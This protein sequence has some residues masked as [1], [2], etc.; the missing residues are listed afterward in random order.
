MKKIYLL[1]VWAMMSMGAFAD[2]LPLTGLDRYA[3]WSYPLIA[4]FNAQWATI[5]LVSAD[6]S[7]SE[8]YRYRIV[9]SQPAP[10][11]FQ[12]S[13]Q[14]AAEASAYSGQYLPIDSGATVVAGEFNLSAFQDGDTYVTDFRLQSIDSKTR[15]AYI[16]SVILYNEY[17]EPSLQVP[18][19]A[20]WSSGTAIS[21]NGPFVFN[22]PSTYWGTTYYSQLGTWNNTLEEGYV[23]RITLVTK[24]TIPDG[25]VFRYTY[26]QALTQEKDTTLVVETPVPRSTSNTFSFDIP[27]TYNDLALRFVG[28]Q[29]Q[30]LAVDRIDR[31]TLFIPPLVYDVENT[32]ATDAEPDYPSVEEAPLIEKLPDPFAWADGSGRLTEFKDWSRRRGEIAH[33]IQHYEIGT[34]PAVDPSAVKARMVGDTLV[35]DVTVNGQTLTLRSKITY[36]EGGHA[37]YALMI[38]MNGNVG[39]LPY[40]LFRG[41]NIATMTFSSAQVNAY[42]QNS[43]QT[44]ANRS[45]YEFVKLYPD[46]ID[47]GAYAEWPWGVSRLID[48]LQQLGSDST[49]IDVKHIGVTGCSYAGK[50]ALFSG[51]FDERVALTIAQEPGGG[52]VAAWRVSHQGKGT[53]AWSNT[54]QKAGGV[55]TLDAT[56]YNWFKESLRDTYGQD[57]VYRLPYD[58][59]ELVAM[60]CPRAVLMLGNP[61]YTWLAD[62][63]GYVSMNAARKVWQ[64]FGIEDRIGYSIVGGHG[65]CSLPE[66]QYDEVG[67]FIDKFLLG[68]DSVDTKDI[69]IA[70]DIKDNPSADPVTHV[71]TWID[72]WGTNADAMLPRPN[73][74]WHYLQAENM[75]DA[76][77]GTSW[78]RTE[79]ANVQEGAYMTAPEERFVEVPAEPAK[80]LSG[81]FEIEELGDYYIYGLVNADGR[82]HDACWISFDDNAPSRANGLDTQGEWEWKNL[83][84][85][86]DDGTR[87]DFKC[88]LSPGVHRVNIF[89]KETE[90]KLDAICISNNDTLPDQTPTNI[91]L[92]ELS[93][94]PC[95]LTAV[96]QNSTGLSLEFQ[97][98]ERTVA[99]ISLHDTSGRLIAFRSSVAIPTGEASVFLPVQS[100]QSLAIL[101]VRTDKGFISRKLT[102][103][104]VQ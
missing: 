69:E 85:S 74:H 4:R 56:D 49:K 66:S 87:D 77:Q 83:S 92:V 5:N 100:A 21:L 10:R 80:I 46:L 71:D 23:D 37:P 76:S 84:K 14:N 61:D 51:A 64:Q 2:S 38:G 59:H 12:L 78:T 17:D 103:R 9:F 39:S 41:K 55:E 25:F 34:K 102:L 90:L 13:I 60:I 6:F 19:A 68:K 98:S 47:N 36:P 53:A 101:S 70:P 30:L 26:Q 52:G 79:D 28:A 72:W 40:D 94:G 62:R 96:R 65:H 57:N 29:R 58:H 93:E 88:T 42:Q 99:S 50:M 1:L 91:K 16:D 7:A 18:S 89:A 43:G 97:S 22:A 63:S 24:D 75:T 44:R 45:N 27:R 32:S 48:G 11:G 81:T 35:V 15:Y 104:P 82:T 95:K 73:Y 67:R 3:P 31:A 86:I 20:G 33:Q 8:F 54:Y